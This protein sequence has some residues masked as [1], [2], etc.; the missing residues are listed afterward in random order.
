MP[1][2]YTR[3]QVIN[4]LKINKNYELYFAFVEQEQQETRSIGTL[5][6]DLEMRSRIGLVQYTQDFHT[7]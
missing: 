1:E 5:K 6:A 3:D 7:L 2:R 4:A